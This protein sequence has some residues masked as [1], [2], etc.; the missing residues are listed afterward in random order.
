MS[1]AHNFRAA[2]IVTYLPIG[3]NPQ[4]LEFKKSLE[5][6]TFDA[7]PFWELQHA[8]EWI[9]EL[10]PTPAGMSAWIKAGERIYSQDQ[11]VAAYEQIPESRNA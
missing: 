2:A 4:G 7:I 5:D 6:C 9:V 11:I 1:D 3:E 8:L 10:T